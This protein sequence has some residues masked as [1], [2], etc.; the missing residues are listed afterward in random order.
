[1]VSRCDWQAFERVRGAD[2]ES[3]TYSTLSSNTVRNPCFHLTARF[4]K[5]VLF[6]KACEELGGKRRILKSAKHQ[7]GGTGVPLVCDVTNLEGLETPGRAERVERVTSAQRCE[8]TL[9][10][11][12]PSTRTLVH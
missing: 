10:G 2:G 9:W 1:M 8:S 4:T 12:H 6:V 3:A 7:G 5:S 11:D